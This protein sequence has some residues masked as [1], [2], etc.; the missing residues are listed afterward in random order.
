MQVLTHS[1]SFQLTASAEQLSLRHLASNG[2]LFW[3]QAH[4]GLM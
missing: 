1:P 3:L 2:T 4:G